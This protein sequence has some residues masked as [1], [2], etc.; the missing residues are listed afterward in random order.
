MQVVHLMTQLDL[1]LLQV[2]HRISKKAKLE[3][4]TKSLGP[5]LE[6]SSRHGRVKVSRCYSSTIVRLSYLPSHATCRDSV[7]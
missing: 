7:I 6:F 3:S 1:D 2:V 5:S 4:Q